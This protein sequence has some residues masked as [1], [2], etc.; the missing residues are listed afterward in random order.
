MVLCG[1]E[2]LEVLGQYGISMEQSS[3]LAAWAWGQAQT[4]WYLELSIVTI[5]LCVQNFRILCFWVVAY[6]GSTMTSLMTWFVKVHMADCL[7]MK[8]GSNMVNPRDINVNHQPEQAELK[9]TVL[10]GGGILSKLEDSNPMFKVMLKSLFYSLPNHPRNPRSIRQLY[11]L[12]NS[13][14]QSDP[15]FYFILTQSLTWGLNFPFLAQIA[16]VQISPLP[17]REGAWESQVN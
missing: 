15:I 10:L 9:R 16:H 8:S 3:W 13:L 6:T 1:A 17:A 5:N 14:A 7:S 4:L 2:T 12:Y 11:L